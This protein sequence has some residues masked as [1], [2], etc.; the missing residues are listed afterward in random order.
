MHEKEKCLYFSDAH[1]SNLEV[2]FDVS[3]AF[4]TGCLR[5]VYYGSINILEEAKEPQKQTTSL[6]T[7]GT[8]SSLFS[9]PSALISK[10]CQANSQQ[11]LSIIF[12]S[13][14]TSA[15]IPQDTQKAI[16]I[17]LS[18]RLPAADSSS[19][20]ALTAANLLGAAVDTRYGAGDFQ[21]GGCGLFDANE[22]VFV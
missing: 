7:R 10:E 20:K 13:Q 21:V 6:Y 8:S 22:A 3:T 12:G 18:F 9:G 15:E 14:E 5:R 4:F 1:F 17:G 2:S 19:L 11:D 16:D